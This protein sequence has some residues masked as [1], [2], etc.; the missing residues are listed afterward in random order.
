MS[1]RKYAIG[2]WYPHDGGPCPVPEESKVVVMWIA[3]EKGDWRA[4]DIRDAWP[5]VVAFCVTE[6]PDEEETRTGK[7]DARWH[8]GGYPVLPTSFASGA[9]G[10]VTGTFTTT[11]V[12][13]KP[14]RIVWEADE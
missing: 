12:N 14:K 1:E 13:G 2:R 6:Y 9:Y 7:I 4:K 5:H 11:I 3:G 8:E 10:T